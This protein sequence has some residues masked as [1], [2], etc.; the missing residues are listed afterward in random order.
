VPPVS[1]LSAG[2]VAPPNRCFHPDSF[3]ASVCIKQIANIAAHFGSLH[4]LSNR[5]S[6]SLT[7]E[8]SMPFSSSHSFA[9][10]IVSHLSGLG[11]VV[12]PAGPIAGGGPG[13]Q[14]QPLCPVTSIAQRI[15]VA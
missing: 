6:P 14:F 2:R 10:I 13:F 9:S 3:G 5:I 1:Q 11:R 4:A 7:E 12:G 8:G 15:F